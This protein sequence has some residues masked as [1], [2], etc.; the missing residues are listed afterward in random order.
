MDA[1]RFASIW[2]QV[3]AKA[4]EFDK[5]MGEKKVWSAQKTMLQMQ[6]LQFEMTG[7]MANPLSKRVMDDFNKGVQEYNASW[8][9]KS[10]LHTKYF[11]EQN[12]EAML[13]TAEEAQRRE[14]H[15][16]NQNDVKYRIQLAQTI[17]TGC[18]GSCRSSRRRRRRPP[19][20]GSCARRGS[21]CRIRTG[22]RRPSP[23]TKTA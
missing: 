22:C 14:L 9:E 16:A 4:R 8:Q 6:D 12:W 18:C 7:G 20:P 10:A 5:Q 19:G 17:R 3:E 23:G 15:P 1:K 2:P 21:S 13:Q 11:T